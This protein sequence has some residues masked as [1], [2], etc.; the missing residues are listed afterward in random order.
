LMPPG[1]YPSYED[2]R[3]NDCDDDDD[4]NRDRGCDRD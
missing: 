2:D 1:A 3:S 4:G